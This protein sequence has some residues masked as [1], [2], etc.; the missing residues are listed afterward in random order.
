MSKKKQKSDKMNAV[1]QFIL[2]ESQIPRVNIVTYLSMFGKMYNLDALLDYYERAKAQKE[3]NNII[4]ETIM[5]DLRGI[6]EDPQ[7]F[8]PRSASSVAGG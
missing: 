1:I 5:H 4:Y 2:D 6:R 3:D 7:T 8:V